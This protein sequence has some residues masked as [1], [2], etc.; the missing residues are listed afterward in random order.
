[1]T[2]YI[3]EI[4]LGGLAKK[5]EKRRKE[6][7]LIYKDKCEKFIE[8][9]GGK[10]VN[11]EEY[12]RL[13]SLRFSEWLPSQ[14]LLP[15]RLIEIE[16]E[17]PLTIL[18]FS[19]YRIHEF[20]P[21]LDYVDRL[22]MK[23][24]LI[25]YAGDDI[26]RFAPTPLRHLRE[27][28]RILTPNKGYPEE[29][30][31]AGVP[32]AGR[33]RFSARFGF[34]LRLSK[35]FDS[36]A[37]DRVSTM[38]KLVHDIRE[39]L[40]T[41]L[42]E[43][44]EALQE[45]LTRIS[46]SLK[47][48]VTKHTWRPTRRDVIIKDA[49]TKTRVLTLELDEDGKLRKPLGGR[50]YWTLYRMCGDDV[51]QCVKVHEDKQY[52][53]YF[54]AANQPDRNFFEELAKRAK[55]GLLAV[56]GNDEGPEARLWIYGENVYDLH[57]TVFK[58]GPFLITGIEG[59][60]DGL[61]D[62]GEYL[63]GD[64]KLRLE[65]VQ[66]MLKHD[67]RLIII[68]HTPPRGVLDR[69]LRYGE[70][71]IG[72]LALR[73]F[74]EE[75]KRVCLVICG[76]VHNCGGRYD[77]LNNAVIVNVSSHDDPYSRANVALIAVEPGGNVDVKIDKLPSL[78]EY[79]FKR[80]TTKEELVEGTRLSDKEAI[81]FI[82][83]VKKYGP[84]I[85][86]HLEDLA[87][88]KF[89]YGLPWDIV[90]K[91]YER[92]IRRTEDIN[93]NVFQDVLTEARGLNRAHLRRARAKFLREMKKGVVGLLTPFPLRLS[94]KVIIFDTEYIFD[95][96]YNLERG[97]LYGFLDPSTGEV[98]QFW[99]D[100]VENAI[101]YLRDKKGYVFVHYGGHDKRILQ[102]E[103][104]HNA[105]TFNLLYFVQTS[106]VAPIDSTFLEYVHDALC[107]R[108]NDKWWETYFYEMDG[109]TKLVLCNKILNNPDNLELRKKLA[110]ANK[111]DI[112][113]LHRVMTRIK[114]LPVIKG[115]SSVHTDN[116]SMAGDGVSEGSGGR[117]SGS[118]IKPRGLR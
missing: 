50:G 9:E 13:R 93:E 103:L 88:I 61:G 97:I 102:E 6:L 30:V 35:R 108:M 21:L 42:L 49:S 40:Q 2:R 92:G 105:P 73:D 52:F 107:G 14:L 5:I 99:F 37:R 115:S 20:E 4:R 8:E 22:G 77:R 28:L 31:E 67:D 96:K 33:Y 79:L 59:S 117:L 98:K 64:V 44:P 78:L 41:S 38:L 101:K 90:F 113:A 87:R 62:S 86:E 11:F 7:F 32:Y 118:I 100:K 25:V 29:L 76:H 45:F 60:T 53:Y 80:G 82:E 71:A 23:P 110:E 91:F 74:I 43:S 15:H 39:A 66:G 72:C 112:I 55:Y 54:V 83:V 19:D 85:Y 26:M 75:E 104:H 16:H 95:T 24:D 12:K 114:E 63:E 89:R 111:A 36:S 1:M 68:S 17:G 56:I 65:F 81:Y 116:T 27:S 18:A 46:P 51:P 84:E 57:G 70:E 58:V 94:E 3:K 69:A 106:L 47:V 10:K 48:E 109:H 34:I